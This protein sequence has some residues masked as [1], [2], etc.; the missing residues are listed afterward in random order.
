MIIGGD[1]V[2]NWIKYLVLVASSIISFIFLYCLIYLAIG[3]NELSDPETLS[4]P[5]LAMIT[6]IVALILFTVW[7]FKYSAKSKYKT[8]GLTALSF[9]IIG[10]LC[11]FLSP[12]INSLLI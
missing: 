7:C 6:S 5:F 10:V 8:L 11:F 4:I 1:S 2:K 12:I 3:A 9:G